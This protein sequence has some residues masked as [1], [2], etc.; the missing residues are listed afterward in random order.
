MD[1]THL[2]R[3]RM[4][5]YLRLYRYL[6]KPFHVGIYNFMKLPNIVHNWYSKVFIKEF[7]TSPLPKTREQWVWNVKNNQILNPWG[8][9]I[10][11]LH[12]LFFKK[13]PFWDTPH[14]WKSGFYCLPQ[15]VSIIKDGIVI[16]DNKTVSYKNKE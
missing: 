3:R 10:P 14:Y 12:F 6:G 15:D 13:T 9:E 7:Y 16:F 1:L 11:Y 5:S 4:V 2:V 8:Q